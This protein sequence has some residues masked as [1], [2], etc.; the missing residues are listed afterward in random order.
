[1]KK[2]PFCAEEIQDEA[3]KCR[4]CA[5]FLSRP[6]GQ[7]FFDKPAEK[8]KKW[9]FSTSAVVVALFCLGPLALPLAWVNPRYNPIAKI[10][11]TLVVIAVTICAVYLMADIYRR[12][13][14]QISELGMT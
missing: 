8:G 2:C 6:A 4:Y 13:M 10:I 1:M 11:V 5:E 7:V 12:L 3:I 9:Y 14:E